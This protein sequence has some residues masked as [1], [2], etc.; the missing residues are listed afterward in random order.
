MKSAFVPIYLLQICWRAYARYYLRMELYEDTR[1]LA[2]SEARIVLPAEQNYPDI[3]YAILS[4]VLTHQAHMTDEKVLIVPIAP[5]ESQQQKK[6]RIH[7]GI[8]NSPGGNQPLTKVHMPTSQ[9]L[10]YRYIPAKPIV[11]PEWSALVYFGKVS[12]YSLL[13]SQPVEARDPRKRDRIKINTSP[14]KTFIIT[15]LRLYPRSILSVEWDELQQPKLY[16]SEDL[17]DKDTVEEHVTSTC[18]HTKHS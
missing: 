9:G 16:L 11:E 13:K 6:R 15:L 12:S 7:D 17:A 5:R 8:E 14:T 18:Y 10:L 2:R 4:D 3:Y 1:R